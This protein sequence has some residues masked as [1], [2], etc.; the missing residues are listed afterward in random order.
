MTERKRRTKMKRLTRVIKVDGESVVVYTKGKYEDTTAA[1][2]EYKDV[3]NVMRRL[4]EYE[5]TGLDPEQ[6]Q[7]LKEP[8]LKLRER[9]GDAL[10]V[11]QVVDFFVDFYIV[12][13][14]TDRVEEAVLLTNEAVS[15]YK[16]LK[17][18]DTAKSPEPAPLGMEGM[19]CPT[20]GCKAVPWTKFCDECGQR[21]L[22]IKV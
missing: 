13:G 18:R 22:E 12:Q 14:D 3:R 11:N 20:C 5:D 4:S 8:I 7:E 1:E 9:F 17:D 10:T 19:V 15:E 21:F 6:I 2:M 16:E